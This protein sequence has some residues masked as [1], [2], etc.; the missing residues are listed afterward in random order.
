M[1]RLLFVE[2]DKDVIFTVKNGLELLNEYDVRCAENGKEGLELF[3]SFAPDVVVTDVEMPIMNGFELARTIRQI[4]EDVVIMIASGLT[5][6]TDLRDGFEISI[7]DYIRKPYVFNEIHWRVQAI[8][9]RMK[10]GF[11]NS[12]S[13]TSQDASDKI[14][15][16]KYTFDL[17]KRLLCFKDNKARKLTPRETD[18]LTILDENRNQ[19]VKRSDILQRFWGKGDDEYQSRS[20]D[21]FIARLRN[22]LSEDVNVKIV[23]EKG[24]GLILEVS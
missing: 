17:E 12:Q 20:L 11:D 21:V 23:N 7:D 22:C 1:I 10:Q 15:I 16:G 13:G 3:K 24:R 14:K 18:I 8:L 5:D 2:D 4:D 19:L 9:R 6:I